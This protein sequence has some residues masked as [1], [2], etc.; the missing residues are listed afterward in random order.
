M[1]PQR[2]SLCAELRAFPGGR[3]TLGRRRLRAG[4]AAVAVFLGGLLS[5]GA[6]QAEKTDVVVLG[7]G[8]RF[9]GEIK[10]MSRGKLDFKT[11]DAGRLSIEW[12]KIVSITS[13]HSFEV[14]MASGKKYYGTLSSPQDYDLQVGP[15]KSDVV[16]MVEVITM[17]PMDEFFWAKVKA[18]LDLGL[19]LA[20]SNS[21]M[22]LSGDGEF[23]YRGQHFGGAFDFN[24]Y[25]QRDK[26]STAVGQ[27][28]MNLTGTYFF[29]AWRVQIQLGY[30]HN[31]E[32]DLSYRV[33]LGAGAAYPIVRN[34]WNELWLSA[35][36]VGAQEQ[37]KSGEPNNNLAAYVGED[38]EAFIYDSPKL[39]AGITTQ[40]IPV[41]TELWRTRGNVTAKVKYEVFSDFFVGCNFSFTFDTKPPDPTAAKTD[42]LLSITL[43][44]S[45][46]Q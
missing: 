21:S 24:T 3:N 42:Y 30:D 23:A 43:G 29:S 13:I 15:E 35:G 44:W 2:T 19:T 6:A 18:Y 7:N 33:D 4:G 26:N 27:L 16:V 11:D 20:K 40:I 37:Y 1:G 5:A 34:K 31:D 28:S 10:G 22:T 39:N 8:D 38:W 9:T 46:R 17:T 14:E 32:L 45:Y 12:I 36:V 41:L 25:W